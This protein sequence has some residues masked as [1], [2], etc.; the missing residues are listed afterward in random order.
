MRKFSITWDL[1][2]TQRFVIYYIKLSLDLLRFYK[3]NIW[4]VM[5]NWRLTWFDVEHLFDYV[6]YDPFFNLFWSSS[7]K[8]FDWIK[9]SVFNLPILIL[10]SSWDK[11]WVFPVKYSSFLISEALYH[12]IIK[13]F[14]IKLPYRCYS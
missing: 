8:I 3:I 1:R 10:H 14:I 6:S 7:S 13:F 5:L 11:F 2:F 12:H 9:P 4:S